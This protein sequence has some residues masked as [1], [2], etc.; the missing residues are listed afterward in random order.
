MAT[1]ESTYP[2]TANVV[3]PTGD[4]AVRDTGVW[5]AR[6]KD[7]ANEANEWIRVDGT[8]LTF[9]DI[10]NA[11]TNPALTIEILPS[12]TIPIE[13]YALG[14]GNTAE[15]DSEVSTNGVLSVDVKTENVFTAKEIALLL[16]SVVFTFADGL[17]KVS[18][19]ASAWSS[20]AREYSYGMVD[21]PTLLSFNGRSYLVPWTY[22][23]T[24][25]STI[26][27]VPDANTLV[28]SAKPYTSMDIMYTNGTFGSILNKLVGNSWFVQSD[29]TLYDSPKF[30][31][32]GTDLNVYGAVTGDVDIDVISVPLITVT[33]Q[34]GEAD[35]VL[36]HGSY[37]I[38]SQLPLPFRT[39]DG[40][41]LSDFFMRLGGV[42]ATL[43][44]VSATGW[45]DASDDS[46]V[47]SGDALS[48]G[49]AVYPYF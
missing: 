18:G 16:D 44:G 46:I 40:I 22:D 32:S 48:D 25:Y 39:P 11:S 42:T 31:I 2:L 6:C 37:N 23:P 45:K 10:Y 12:F 36:L 43:S 1:L 14:T 7:T 21:M 5:Y 33:I 9:A 19:L 13:I 26:T 30:E 17:V 28:S 8:S 41:A 38:T 47:A 34:L 15:Y 35:T 49:M 3:N 20:L 24:D 29:S 27:L 4:Y